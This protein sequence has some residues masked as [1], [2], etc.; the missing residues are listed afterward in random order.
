MGELR[1]GGLPIKLQEQPARVLALLLLNKGDLVGR[2]QLRSHLWPDDTFVDFEHSLNTAIKKLREALEDSADRPN[3]IETL[4]RK[5]YRFIAAVVFGQ[6]S[7]VT[8]DDAT[9][10]SAA[11][12]HSTASA[13][14]EENAD[15]RGQTAER[16]SDGPESFPIAAQPFSPTFPAPMSAQSRR[17]PWWPVAAG[18]LV[19]A[20]AALGLWAGRRLERRQAPVLHRLTFRHGTVWNARF[21][22][23]G[24]SVVYGAAWEGKPV[25]IFESRVDLAEARAL[26]ISGADVLA[27]S[28]KGEMAVALG[29]QLGPSG[30]SYNGTLARL[31]LTGGVPREVMERVE[32]ADWAPDGSLAITYHSQGKARL[33]FPIGT[34]R[35]ESATW[36]SHVRVSPKG[37]MVAFIEHDNPIGDGGAVRVVGPNLNVQLTRDYFGSAQGLA[38][39]PA[40]SEIWYTA[41]DASG[42]VRSLHAVDL[43][44]HDRIV[45]RVPGTLKLLDI[46]KDGRVLLVHEQIWA[47]ILAHIPDEQGERELGW[48]DWSIGRKLSDDGKWLLFDESGAA[49]GDH[50]WVYLRGTNGAPPVLL[51][52]GAYCDLSADGKWVASA[53]IETAGQIN[54]LPTG[55]GEA[56]QLHFPELRIYRVMWLPDEEHIVISASNG[57]KTLRGYV[58]D[59]KTSAV[60][61]FTPEGVRLHSAVSPDGKFIAGLGADRRTY[62]FPIDSGPPRSVKVNADERVVGWTSDGLSLYAAAATGGP[63]TSIYRV[64]IATGR[65]KL[66]RTLS[67]LEQ[68][69]ISYIG[70]GYVTPDG[71]YYVYSYNRQLSELFVIEG[72]K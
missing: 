15:P 32:S 50:N 14:P 19:C 52:E 11:D 58:V 20:A 68:T 41:G 6:A 24:N 25:E 56:R 4:P 65:R 36:I 59:L 33:E 61:A 72:L 16:A 46:A 62:L 17:S 23:D 8:P 34:L 12:V 55:A 47:G 54:L 27:I 57:G 2:E 69:G 7:G 49:P 9:A 18:L 21:T 22:P 48:L 43:Q 35:Y 39:S 28:D 5:G 53:P 40:G 10:A 67:P 29:R 63:A 13:G 64:D 37:G 51:G 1:R 44:G 70:P 45:Y 42:N 60:R 66:S 30:F 26:G 38:W 71:R 3:Y 31:S